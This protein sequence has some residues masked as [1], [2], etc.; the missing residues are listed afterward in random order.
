MIAFVVV[1]PYAPIM[2]ILYSIKWGFWFLIGIFKTF[3][4]FIKNVKNISYAT[5]E[6]KNSAT[7]FQVLK[8]LFLEFGRS[9]FKKLFDGLKAIYNTLA[10]IGSEIGKYRYSILRFLYEKFILF[11]FSLDNIFT[12]PGRAWLARRLA[13][14]RL[15]NSE[16]KRNMLNTLL[17]ISVIF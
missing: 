9:S 2:S 14:E 7:F 13:P 12:R 3:K 10:Y 4:G 11:I 6:I 15:W 8:T 16:R 1:F 5:T 17:N